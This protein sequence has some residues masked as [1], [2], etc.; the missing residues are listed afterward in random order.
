MVFF[1][2][3][4][5]TPDFGATIGWKMVDGRDFQMNNVADSSGIILNEAALKITQLK[6]PIGE[7][8]K[9]WGGDYRIIG[10]AAD[11]LTQSPYEPTAPSVFIMKGWMSVINIRIKPGNSLQESLAKIETVFKRYSPGSPFEPKFVDQGYARKF[12]DEEKIGDLSTVFATLAV[13]ISCLGLFGLASFVA[14]QR[15]KEIG[16]RKVM[17]ASLSN[18]WQMLSRDFFLLVVVSC[19]ISIPVVLYFLT[20]WLK[21]FDYRTDISWWVFAITGVGA[22]VLTML[23]IS[24]QAIKAGLANPVKSLRSE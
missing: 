15:T 9:F 20:D 19:F 11:M 17:G 6:N 1:R 22:L 21:K 14:E 4:S 2:N 8:V 12:S 18:V 3:V 7:T 16:I 10:I 5:V 24:Y 13:F 23:T